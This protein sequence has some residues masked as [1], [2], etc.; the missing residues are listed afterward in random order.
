MVEARLDWARLLPTRL[1]RPSTGRDP[2]RRPDRDTIQGSH[3]RARVYV[4]KGQRQPGENVDDMSAVDHAIPEPPH[5]FE[6]RWLS[7]SRFVELAP[8]LL[9]VLASPHQAVQ[10]LVVTDHCGDL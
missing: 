1:C 10:L 6:D 3:S 8:E 2:V 5:C 7:R 4:R 9:D